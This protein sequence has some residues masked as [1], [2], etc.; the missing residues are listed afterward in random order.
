MHHHRRDPDID[1]L[2]EFSRIEKAVNKYLERTAKA[3]AQI[4]VLQQTGKQ[5]PG[6]YLKNSL[7]MFVMPNVSSVENDSLGREYEGDGVQ[8]WLTSKRERSRL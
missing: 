4:N 5:R 7:K 6:N 8:R 3:A 1:L 2:D